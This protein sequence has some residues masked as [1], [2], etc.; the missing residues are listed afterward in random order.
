MPLSQSPTRQGQ[1][2]QKKSGRPPPIIWTSAANLIQ[3]QKQ[4][5]G[6]AQQSFEFRNTRPR[7]GQMQTTPPPPP[8]CLWCGGGRMHRDCP[9]KENASSTPACCDCQP[10]KERKHIPPTTAAV[11]T[12]GKSYRRSFIKPQLSFAAALRGK[13]DQVHQEVAASTREPEPPKTKSKQQEPGQS[14]P[15]PHCKQ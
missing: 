9:E 11:G 12:P 10:A 6:V 1:Q 3:L 14:V 13:A 5:K 8:G 7:L 2:L 4:L 15:A